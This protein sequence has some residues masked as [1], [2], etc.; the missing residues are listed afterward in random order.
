MTRTTVMLPETLKLEAKE[1][2]KELG[3]SMGEL[4]RKAL[5]DTLDDRTSSSWKDDPLFRD[6]PIFEG[7]TPPDLSSDPDRYL[8]GDDA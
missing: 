3:L 1:R 2:A 5:R 6:V 8:Y 4:I 7:S